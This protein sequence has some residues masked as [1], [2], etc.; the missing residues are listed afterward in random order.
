MRIAGTLT[1][2]VILASAALAQEG[3]D[4]IK[5]GDRVQ[6]TLNNKNVIQGHVRTPVHLTPAQRDKKVSS[7]DFDLSKTPN[8]TL[9]LTYSNP[10]LGKGASLTISRGDIVSVEVLTPLTPEET[11]KIEKA[12]EAERE[13]LKKI[14]ALR[15]EN[16]RKRTEALLAGESDEENAAALEAAKDEEEKAKI[17]A[18]IDLLNRFPPS[19]YGPETITEIIRKATIELPISEEEKEFQRQYGEWTKA[20]EY[21]DNMK[22]EAEEKAAEAEKEAEKATEASEKAPEESG[23]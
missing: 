17:Q 9:D 6:V 19:E 5:V 22:K 1:A 16:E 4:K 10:G 21:L 14:E 23:K 13:N 12:L 15:Q 7:E 18:M 2:L 11:E 3:Y 20:K 8:L